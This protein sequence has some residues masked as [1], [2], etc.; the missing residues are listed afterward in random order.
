MS[1]IFKDQNLEY[2]L[3]KLFSGFKKSHLRKIL[4]RIED[5]EYKK[6][7]INN[8]SSFIRKFSD[9]LTDECRDPEKIVENIKIIIMKILDN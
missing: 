4:S 5:E 9:D 6:Q 8:L 3:T 2:L 1:E 7:V